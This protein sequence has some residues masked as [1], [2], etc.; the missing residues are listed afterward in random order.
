MICL[1]AALGFA[2]DIIICASGTSGAAI[3]LYELIK[4]A[5]MEGKNNIKLM[6]FGSCGG[7]VLGEFRWNLGEKAIQG[8]TKHKCSFIVDGKTL[9]FINFHYFF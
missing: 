2:D 1:F 4:K 3:M 8:T 9:I 5:I 7:R 6:L